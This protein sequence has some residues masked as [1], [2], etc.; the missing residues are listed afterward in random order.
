MNE[1][2]QQR[3]RIA[4]DEY[5]LKLKLEKPLAVQSRQLLRT[6]AN[7][8][9]AIF[10]ASEE[11]INANNYRDDWIGT[12][13]PA[14]RKTV[15][16]FGNKF[17]TQI[18]GSLSDENPPLLISAFTLLAARLGIPV[19]DALNGFVARKNAALIEFV[20]N[21]VPTRADLITETNQKEIDK[22]IAKAT[23]TAIQEGTA[24]DRIAIAKTAAKNFRSSSIFRG[25]VIGAT[26][27]QNAAEGAKQVE[28]AVLDKEF[29]LIRESGDVII[30]KVK[31]WHT[32]GDEKV[33]EDHVR[34][35]LQSRS[36]EAA[37]DVGGERLMFPGDRSLGATAA[38]IINCRCSAIYFFDGEVVRVVSLG[39][40][41]GFFGEISPGD[42]PEGSFPLL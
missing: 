7:D 27:T 5:R 17:V 40:D 6:M 25:S 35:D 42:I 29:E 37:F 31:E 11:T 1:S 21:A 23:A 39:S 18:R 2:Q 13:R 19:K 3:Q 32:Q 9:E 12:L 34:A 15:N 28:A 4:D 16:K 30:S 22:A 8:L 14:Y 33:R 38:Q 41:S 24:R 26:E 36:F 20:N 10:A